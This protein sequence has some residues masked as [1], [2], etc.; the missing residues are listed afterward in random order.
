MRTGFIVTLM[1]GLI[2]VLAA[3]G[4]ALGDSDARESVTTEPCPCE[5]TSVFKEAT[6]QAAPEKLSPF[7]TVRLAGKRIENMPAI[8]YAEMQRGSAGAGTS[9]RRS[10]GS[11]AIAMAASAV[12]PGLGELYV[13]THTHDPWTLARVPVFMG[14]DGYLWYRYGSN[15]DK[16][17]DYKDQ[18]ETYANEHWS[19]DRFLQQHPCCASLGGCDSWQFYNS[20]GS[21]HCSVNFF[22]FTPHDADPEEYYENAGKYDAFAYGW[23]DWTET[24][25]F[26]TPHRTY[27][28]GLR[29]DSDTYL[30]RGDQALMLLIVNRVVS[31]VDAGWVAYRS[32]KGYDPE[33]SWS[34]DLNTMGSAPTLIVSK[35]F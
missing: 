30:K 31:M 10:E 5:M 14:I 26:W 9:W 23:D 3:P 28:W 1:V 27:Y 33:K 6:L 18:Y 12:L 13:Y 17:K 2:A 34:I 8:S 11:I 19:L 24:S 16:G 20:L 25:G 35:G 22:I 4:R 21:Q 15:H 7:Q 32:S 29:G